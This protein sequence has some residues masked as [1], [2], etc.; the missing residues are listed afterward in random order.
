MTTTLATTSS[1]HHKYYKN[2]CPVWCMIQHLNWNNTLNS[3]PG[4]WLQKNDCRLGLGDFHLNQL[5]G[6]TLPTVSRATTTMGSFALLHTSF[7]SSM[8]PVPSAFLSSIS[9]FFVEA[10]RRPTSATCRS[11]LKHKGSSDLTWYSNWTNTYTCF[12]CKWQHYN[13]QQTQRVPTYQQQ[14]NRIMQAHHS[15]TLNA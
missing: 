12:L 6:T 4:N 8:L 10:A 2:N 15:V 3:L 11:N 1:D 5:L 7:A 13:L 9:T 14:N